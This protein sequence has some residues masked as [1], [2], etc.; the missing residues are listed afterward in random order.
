MA[1]IKILQAHNYY[2]QAGGEDT[3]FESDV[4]LLRSHGHEV[5]TYIENNARIPAIPPA[6]L[7]MQT[8]WSGDSYN[9]ILK[10]ID[11]EKPD[12]VHFH[13]TFPLISPAAYYA[14]RKAGV[15]VIQSLHNPRLMCPAAS[16]YRDNKNCIECLGKR[17][18]YP[19]VIYAC[20]HHS[21]IQTAV[22]ATML[23]GHRIHGTWNN[24]VD[25][26]LVA[27]TFYRDLFIRAGLPEDK[28]LIKPHFV[29]SAPPLDPDR[30]MGEYALFIGRLDP[31]KGI[32]VLLEAW[33]NVDIP[34]KIRGSGQ[35]EA[36]VRRFIEQDHSKNIEIIDRLTKEDLGLLI[37][38]ARFL[39]WPTESYYETFGFVA[40]E[41][42][43]RGV[44][45][46]GSR[47]GVNAEIVQDGRTGLHFTAGDPADLAA[48]VKWAWE[49]PEQMRAMGRNALDEYEAKYTP[50]RNYRLLLDIYQST[51]HS[52]Q[53]EY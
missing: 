18:P 39:I 1:K 28:V 4:A 22:T 20:Y 36:E 23:A 14:C 7:A 45:V 52:R 6:R 25:K 49:H 13:N 44:P 21:R 42:Y 11:R 26:Y 16:F 15:P 41:S 48:K 10:L 30:R 38:R 3:V 51:L 17:L 37:E 24:M 46:I 29:E 43:A 5:I 47:I 35:L 8:V 32:R 2:L 53:Q 40:V 34:L 50:E 27:S 9:K 31:E 33:K 19:G 12:I